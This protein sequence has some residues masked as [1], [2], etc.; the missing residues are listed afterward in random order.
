[1]GKVEVGEGG[2]KVGVMVVEAWALLITGQEMNLMRK[3]RWKRK[4]GCVVW[5][6]EEEKR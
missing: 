5:I 1:M 6:S 2:E 3:G 4:A